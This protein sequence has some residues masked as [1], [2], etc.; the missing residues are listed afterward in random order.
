[1]TDSLAKD[2]I[3]DSPV[4]GHDKKWRQ[5]LRNPWACSLYTLVTTAAAFAALFLMVQ[6]FLVRQLD[7][8]GCEMS[9]M[10]PAYIELES[11]DME[12]TRFAS[13]YSLYL[14]REGGIDEDPRVRRPVE[15]HK[16]RTDKMQV[17]GVPV[18][19][20]PGNAGSYKQVRSLA[21]EA[22]YHYHNN[23][24]EDV[25]AR[26]AGK[27]PLDFF[28]V[29][30]NEDIT[31]F[32]GQTLLDQADY[33]NDAIAYILSLYHTP[34]HVLRDS[35][36]PDPASVIIVGHSMG[37][38]VART[39]LTMP[40]YQARSINTIITLA[41]PHARPP[42]SFDG[43]IVRTYKGVND[44]WRH[45][46][47]QKWAID[48]PLW[49]VTLIS[50]AGGGLD[51]MISSDYAAIESFV[52]ET[53][54][55]TVFTSSM[56]NVWTGMDHLAITWCD[57]NRKSVIRALYD[58][59]DASR[60]TQ[61]V[62]RAQRMRGF[63]KWFLSG[64]EDVT[65]KTLPHKEAKTLLTLEEDSAI[66]PQGERLVI[67]NLGRNKQTPHAY[68][69]AVP[70]LD[71]ERRKFTLLT[72]EK[73]D[74]LGEHGTLEVLFCSVFP[75]APGQSTTLFSMNMD[76]SGDSTGA[77]RLACKNAASDIIALPASTAQSTYP[78]KTGQRPFSYLQYE[79]EDLAEYKFVAIVD[80]SSGPS[81]GWVVA[82]F[83]TTSDSLVKVDMGLQR[84]LTTGLSFRLP[85]RRPLT[86]D[87][88]VPA[89]H[90]SLLAY[91][92]H[93]TKQS[94]DKGELF[95][96]LLRQYVT[97][98]YESKFFV[99]VQ[100]AS[101]NLHGV[102]PYMPPALHSKQ[103][104][105]GL[106]LQVWIDPTC[107]SSVDFSLKVDVL[108]SLGKLW[109]RYRIVFAAFPI[110]IVALVLRQ[111]FKVYDE[112]GVFMSFAQ[113]LNECLSTSIPLTL[114]ALTF[115]S[116][117]LAGSR[118]QSVKYGSVDGAPANATTMLDKADHELLLGSDDPFFWF[119]VPLFGL[120]CTGI[121]VTVNYIALL[122]EYIFALIY[123]SVRRS[124][125]RKDEAKRLPSAFAATPTRQRILTSCI[126][127]SLVSTVIPYHFAYVILCLVQLATSV[128]SFRLARE[129]HLDSHY[130]FHNYTHSI[131]ILMLWILPIN[132]PVLV[133]WIRNLTIHWLTPFSP[134]H[135][136]LSIMP[137]V[138]LVETLSAGR[139][140]PRNVQ[141]QSS[142]S[143][144]S[145]A[146]VTNVLLFSIG[147]Y[148][149]VYG[150]TYAYVLHQLANILCAWLVAVHFFDVSRLPSYG[151]GKIRGSW[152]SLLDRGTGGR[153]VDGEETKK[154]P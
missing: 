65:E 113:S 132:L 107:D 104:T 84:L 39:M 89:L 18:L 51:T 57:Q 134:H 112:T 63:K 58:V 43:D 93:I 151:V 102:S 75:S 124:T 22:A 23:I 15:R 12:H 62:T 80:K 135:N 147:A 6:S 127:L 138:F 49:H 73:L 47:S 61:T 105:N 16:Q 110:L 109:M 99:N 126:L 86:V 150:V 25:G 85:A 116:I 101:I 13:K 68:L 118:H 20:I 55:F 122:L 137:F 87:I 152:G 97:D 114:A 72:N 48:N 148:A 53:H 79:L 27:R 153:G 77:T 4:E 3:L 103:P 42:V 78:F 125:P 2:M 131:L 71:A 154:R 141:S 98:V 92:V 1:M 130:N 11:F 149:A 108:G 139:M 37:G 136:I 5:R 82:E 14:Y 96:P 29:D 88:K 7:V 59:I 142:R 46:Y 10:R 94:C 40:N 19:F 83:S 60:A 100:D 146:M 36:L 133:V 66:V 123:S 76:L 95:A 119:L 128:R 121:C 32:H 54:G 67:R 74:S 24:R 44:Y 41:A 17:K 120:M 52:P 70:P 140:V 33:L 90:S 145:M 28:S 117:V 9:Y 45:A 30:F 8:K 35:H 115:L 64:L 144:I 106:S 69:F 50:I 81:A 91:N 31:A 56:P 21:S 111:Q 143:S 34:G 38:V 129:T 26:Q